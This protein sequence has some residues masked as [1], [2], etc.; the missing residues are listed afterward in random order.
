MA[1]RP[2][3]NDSY[4]S[5]SDTRTIPLADGPVRIRFSVDRE[6]MTDTSLD[7]RRLEQVIREL[8]RGGIAKLQ[9]GTLILSLSAE[10][11]LRRGMYTI[12]S[13]GQPGVYGV[14]TGSQKVALLFTDTRAPGAS[15]T[16][17]ERRKYDPERARKKRLAELQEKQSRERSTA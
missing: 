6:A 11:H 10:G 5:R 2:E 15:Y 14:T 7:Q 9:A 17:P 1:R 4:F 3:W 12:V 8:W 16:G 13:T